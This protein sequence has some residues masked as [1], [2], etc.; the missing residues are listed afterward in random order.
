MWEW[1]LDQFNLTNDC[2]DDYLINSAQQDG[3]IEHQLDDVEVEQDQQDES[4][5]PAG[6]VNSY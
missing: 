5:D 6:I 3:L 4:H 2:N 1:V